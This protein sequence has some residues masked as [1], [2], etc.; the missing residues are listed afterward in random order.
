MHRHRHRS[1]PNQD[2]SAARHERAARRALREIE[3][4]RAELRVIA[5]LRRDTRVPFRDRDA[6]LELVLARAPRLAAEPH[7]SAI[8][9]LLAL[10]HVRALVDWKPRGKGRDSLF[11]SLAEH[12]LAR[13]PTPPLLWTAFF[14]AHADH[15]VPLVR[16]IAA[17]QS[18]AVALQGLAFPIP[19]TRRQ[20]HEILH[21]PAAGTFFRAI[22]RAQVRAAGGDARLISTWPSTQCS[23]RLGT[24]EQEAFLASFVTWLARNDLPA[25]QVDPVVDY[26]LHRTANEASFS[27]NGRSAAATLRGMQEWHRE[28][29][30]VEV[31]HG[32]VY[33][34]SGLDPA[35][36]ELSDRDPDGN[37]SKKI[38]RVREI[39]SGK[40][41]AEEGR[42]MRHCV[43]SYGP[44]IERRQISIWSLTL[45][46]GEGPTGHWAMLTIEVHNASRR[47][48]Q[49]RGRCNRSATSAE[50]VILKRWAGANGLTVLV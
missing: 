34:P 9:R 14:D 23:Q 25:R 37:V 50:H 42:R 45:E 5:A 39:L 35:T 31:L 36:Y 49:A 7:F 29:A 33:A 10:E 8:R 40:A 38:W 17:G 48:V 6:R 22:R 12:V 18:F 13:Y 20:C 21:D 1:D 32:T 44:S 11:E 41:L 3:E 27:M 24:P 15:L 43:Y 26:L 19:L 46:D 30:N 28:L 2:Y 4:A 47:V 16:R